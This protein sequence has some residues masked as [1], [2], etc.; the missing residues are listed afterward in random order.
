MHQMPGLLSAKLGAKKRKSTAVVATGGIAASSTL[1]LIKRHKPI[2][3]YGTDAGLY[4]HPHPEATI[5]HLKEAVFEN[6]NSANPKVTV[7]A[8]TNECIR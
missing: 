3:G 1:D 5:V 8:A 6:P 4:A 2:D 7:T